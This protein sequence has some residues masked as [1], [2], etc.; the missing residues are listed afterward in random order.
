MPASHKEEGCRYAVAPA[1]ESHLPPPHAVKRVHCH[2]SKVSAA[3]FDDESNE[4]EEDVMLVR[5]RVWHLA[6]LVR[7]RE[8]HRHLH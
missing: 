2:F 1:G 5:V 3:T 8:E 4:Q 6:L 7:E